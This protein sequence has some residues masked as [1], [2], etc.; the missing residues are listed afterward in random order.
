MNTIKDLLASVKCCISSEIYSK[1]LSVRYGR[2]N[3]NIMYNA[4]IYRILY[5]MMSDTIGFSD[6][7]ITGNYIITNVKYNNV[8]YDISPYNWMFTIDDT[9]IFNNITG[10]TSSWVYT[11]LN[12]YQISFVNNSGFTWLFTF[13]EDFN[14]VVTYNEPGNLIRIEAEKI[15]SNL[16][17]TQEQFCEVITYL[18]KT[19]LTC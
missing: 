4:I 14:I 11:T 15:I 2:I 16:C 17:F 10:L 18:N 6:G 19:C 9:T 5:S 1:D 13:D 7:G 8:E 3:K 12:N